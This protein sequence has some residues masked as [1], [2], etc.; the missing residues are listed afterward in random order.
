MLVSPLGPIS[1]TSSSLG[2]SR[3]E[4]LTPGKSQVNLSPGR[5]LKRINTQNKVF[6]FCIRGVNGKSP[7][8]I[9]NHDY[10]N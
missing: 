4:I 8:I 7:Q 3:D 10:N 1:L 9:A 2:G 5:F 6:L